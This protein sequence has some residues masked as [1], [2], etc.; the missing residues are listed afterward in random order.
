MVDGLHDITIIAKGRGGVCRLA[1]FELYD[2]ADRSDIYSRIDAT[3]YSNGSGIKF[4]NNGAGDWVTDDFLT[5]SHINF[6]PPGTTDG[7]CIRYA[8]GGVGGMIEIREGGPTGPVLSEF[9]PARTEGGSNYIEAYIGLDSLDGVHEISFVAKDK[10]SGNVMNMDWFE[11]SQR[12]DVLSRIPATEYSTMDGVETDMYV[13]KNFDEGD[14]V[15]YSNLNFGP[16][17][18]TNSITV[19]YAKRNSNSGIVE[20]RL[21]GPTG[22]LIGEFVPQSTGDW[23]IFDTI[24]ADITASVDGTYDLTFVGKIKNA[25]MNLEWFELSV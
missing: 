13:I 16:S 15:T 18:T 24:T 21:D 17:G 10:A 5:Y 1:W 11:L 25:I 6:G 22:P 4:G 19:S 20:M 3:A 7:I 23:G 9:K 8:K 12:N 2:F 14:Y